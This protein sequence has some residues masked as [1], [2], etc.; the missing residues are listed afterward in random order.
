MNR[1]NGNRLINTEQANG[2]CMGEEW[3]ERGEEIGEGE[4]N[5][6]KMKYESENL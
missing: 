5:Q 6:K 1:K 4:K 3:V 2:C